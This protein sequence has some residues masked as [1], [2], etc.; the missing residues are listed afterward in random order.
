MFSWDMWF[1]KSDHWQCQESCS[2]S[3]SRTHPGILLAPK[4]WCPGALV[5][6]WTSAA[7]CSP[8]NTVWFQAGFRFN[9][10]TDGNPM[11]QPYLIL[12]PSDWI[13]Q[14]YTVKPTSVTTSKPYENSTVSRMSWPVNNGVHF[15]DISTAKSGPDLVCFVNFDLEMCFAPQRRAIFHLSS[16][17]LAPHPPL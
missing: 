7:G 17:Q 16:G 2:F 12:T 13:S 4:H 15:F 5:P 10:Y 11:F 8:R 3:F 14:V 6:W 9:Q 1:L